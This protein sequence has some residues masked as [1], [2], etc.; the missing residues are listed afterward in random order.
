MLAGRLLGRYDR[1]DVLVDNAALF[2]SSYEGA[3][4]GIHSDN[5]NLAETFA[6]MAVGAQSKPVNGVPPGVGAT[7]IW[8]ERNWISWIAWLFQWFYK[9]PEQGA[10][11]PLHPGTSDELEGVTRAYFKETEQ[12]TPSRALYDEPAARRLWHLSAAMTGLA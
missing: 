7:N 2:V 10:E 4:D 5:P 3:P 1:T 9:R 6:G 8:R 12:V 11:G